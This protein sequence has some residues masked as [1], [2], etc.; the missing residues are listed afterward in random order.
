[1]A[2]DILGDRIQTIYIIVNPDKLRALPET[3]V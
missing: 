2:F 3:G 1:M